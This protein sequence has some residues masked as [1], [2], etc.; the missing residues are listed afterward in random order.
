MLVEFAFL[1]TSESYSD[2]SFLYVHDAV[3]YLFQYQVSRLNNLLLFVPDIIL[4]S[5][6]DKLSSFVICFFI[7]LVVSFEEK[8]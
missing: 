2:C 6:Y 3:P 7:L 1:I 4:V 5:R 8:A